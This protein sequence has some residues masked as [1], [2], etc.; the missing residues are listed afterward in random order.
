M[1][2]FK[3]TKVTQTIDH[4]SLYIDW[5]M[6]LSRE[7]CGLKSVQI[8]SDKKINQLLS[9]RKSLTDLSNLND[10]RFVW[11]KNYSL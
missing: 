4:L 5:L 2:E 7:E 6:E 11:P 10:D 3:N 8:I 9:N 1:R